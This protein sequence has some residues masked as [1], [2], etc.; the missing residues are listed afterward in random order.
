ME[1]VICSFPRFKDDEEIDF[2]INEDCDGGEKEASISV[3]I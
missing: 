3:E 1:E 2:D